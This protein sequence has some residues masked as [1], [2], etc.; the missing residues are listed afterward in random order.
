VNKL[1]YNYLSA[2][3]S[4]GEGI[5]D[6]SPIRSMLVAEAKIPRKDVGFIE[7]GQDV[8][9]KMDTFPFTKYGSL[10]GTIESVSKNS[11]EEKDSALKPIVI[12]LEQSFRER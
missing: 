8:R 4:P 9:V 10:R 3:I 6:I 5:A 1:H 7:V 2:V 12:A 11:Y